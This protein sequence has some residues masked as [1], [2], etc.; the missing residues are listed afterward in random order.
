MGQKVR[1]TGIRVG[2]TRDWSS[3]WYADKREFGKLLIE[4]RK[5]REYVKE[6]FYSAGVPEVEIERNG[7]KITVILHAARPG[8]VIGRKGARVDQ[9]RNDLEKI[10]GRE[11][12]L[13]IEEITDPDKN[14]Q[15]IAEGVAD[16]L[17]KRAGFRRVLKQ[18]IR[19]SR[20]RGVKGIKVM[21]AG[22]LGGA[23]MARREHS[24]DGKIPLSTLRADIDFGFAEAKTTYGVIGV[25]VWVYKG[26]ILKKKGNRR[27]GAH[28]QEG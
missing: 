22:R 15:L 1:P 13:N 28:A 3:R 12:Q 7:E 27:H 21:V 8:V 11:V 20:E 10:T 2:I 23:E 14:A 18:T 17:K 6:N 5:I 9:L 24:S 25:K 4:D 19:N 16:Q 26:E